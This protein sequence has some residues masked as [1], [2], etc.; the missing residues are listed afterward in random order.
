MSTSSQKRRN[1][2]QES[3]VSVSESLVSPVLVE[4]EELNDQDIV[5]LGPPHAKSPRIEKHP[6]EPESF[7]KGGDNFGNQRFIVGVSDRVVEIVQA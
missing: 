4:N 7:F 5:V 2:Q 6:R 1:N 3:T